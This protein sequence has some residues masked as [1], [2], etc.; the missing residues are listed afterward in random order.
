MVQRGL[1]HCDRLLR[2]QRRQSAR[3]ARGRKIT[4]T[5]LTTC[6]TL[7]KREDINIAKGTGDPGVDCFYQSAYFAYFEYF[8]HFA[9]F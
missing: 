3:G 7:F 1:Q 4:W 6:S 8:A 5:P 9:Y 2:S